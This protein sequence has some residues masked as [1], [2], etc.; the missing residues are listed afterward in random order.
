VG[1]ALVHD[2]ENGWVGQGLDQ[3]VLED[4][5]LALWMPV[6]GQKGAEAVFVGEGVDNGVLGQQGLYDR[7]QAGA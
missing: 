5:C 7:H 1:S 3:N 4:D 6:S 2:V